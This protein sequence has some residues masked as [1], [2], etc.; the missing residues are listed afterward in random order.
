MA[1]GARGRGQNRL[2]L[3]DQIFSHGMVGVSLSGPI[4][5]RPVVSQGCRPVGEPLVITKAEHNVI[6]E[7][8]G[9]PAV[10]VLHNVFGNAPPRDQELM[11]SGV[12]VGK[13]IDE[14]LESFGY[15]DFLIRNLLGI[16]GDT[17][18]AVNALVRPGQTIQ[19]HVRDSQ[20]ADEEMRS[21][22]SGRIGD[23]PDPPAGALMFN[24]NGRGQHMFGR[25][26]HDI[27]LLHATADCP[28]A[29]FFAAGEIGPV[30]N[31]TFIHGFTS[32]LVLFHKV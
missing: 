32:S 7:L 25:P 6:H 5:I 2:F 21:L 28:T 19:F 13:V 14:H 30:G 31:R 3:N 11:Q 15:G 29:G 17:A 16:V 26:N 27:S 8:R 10:S 1:S 20:T 4:G 12:L 9:R 22:L 24:C 23:L 18:L